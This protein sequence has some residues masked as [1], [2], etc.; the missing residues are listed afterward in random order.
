[1]YLGVTLGRT[2]KFREHVQRATVSVSY[3]ELKSW[4]TF[5]RMRFTGNI[6]LLSREEQHCE[7]HHPKPLF[8]KR[9]C[10]WFPVDL[11]AQERKFIYRQKSGLGKKEPS[12]LIGMHIMTAWQEIW[13]QKSRGRWTARLI[14]SIDPWMGR[15]AGEV[16][17]YLSRF[18][19]LFCS[20]RILRVVPP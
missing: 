18:H 15:K 10:L 1:M 13:E 8:L 7:S 11:L 2:I 19:G 9:Q 5:Y 14:S 3:M 17:Q 20:G 12:K 16:N 6:Q 4:L